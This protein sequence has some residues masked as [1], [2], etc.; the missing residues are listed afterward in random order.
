MIDSLL[1]RMNQGEP[2]PP[3]QFLSSLGEHLA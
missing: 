2:I 1:D 3:E